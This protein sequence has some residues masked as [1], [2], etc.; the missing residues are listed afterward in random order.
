MN[1]LDKP[2]MAIYDVAKITNATAR[3]IIKEPS[4]FGHKEVT[5]ALAVFANEMLNK[6]STTTTQ[7]KGEDWLD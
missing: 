4:V 2:L 6:D 7:L 1:N 5:L 3:E